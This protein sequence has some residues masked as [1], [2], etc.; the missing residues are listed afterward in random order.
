M[1]ISL[2]KK[3]SN[4]LILA[5]LFCVSFAV[6]TKSSKTTFMNISEKLVGAQECQ[7]P[8]LHNP[9][10]NRLPFDSNSRSNACSIDKI[11]NDMETKLFEQFPTEG[12]SIKS[13]KLTERQFFT[14]PNT[15]I[16]N[17]QKEYAQWLYG[18]PN[19]KSCR[20]NTKDCLG[21]L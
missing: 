14:T 21:F 2:Y 7:K 11:H 6:L 12:M 16:I 1:I 3:N 18:Q 4:A 19:A 10:G 5:L 17:D 15:G 8:T 9:M 20:E 13:K